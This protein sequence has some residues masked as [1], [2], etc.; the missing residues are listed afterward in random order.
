MSKLDI[1]RWNDRPIEP[2]RAS[3]QE[4]VMEV[5]VCKFDDEIEC[6]HYNCEEDTSII[7]MYEYPCPLAKKKLELREDFD[8]F[9]EV[10]E[11]LFGEY[12][13]VLLALNKSKEMNKQ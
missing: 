10:Y 1:R 12:S 4:K 13:K 6:A 2:T 7:E 8:K 11:K 3:K 9:K 5:M